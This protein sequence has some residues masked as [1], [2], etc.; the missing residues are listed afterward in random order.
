MASFHP[1]GGMSG[2]GKNEDTGSHLSAVQKKTNMSNKRMRKNAL[3]NRLR[4]ERRTWGLTQPELA[5]LLGCGGRTVVSRIERGKRAPSLRVAIA[6]KVLF[7]YPPHHIFP[8]LY[9]EV[10]D[11]VTRRAYVMLQKLE[12]DHSAAAE[13][14][15]LLL[16]GVLKRA[17]QS[18]EEPHP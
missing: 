18:R 13:Q 12:Q 9:A 7:G 6:C 14:K 10:E 16:A 2:I 4:R 11:G 5:R 1:L 8:N 15:K 17:I 3:S